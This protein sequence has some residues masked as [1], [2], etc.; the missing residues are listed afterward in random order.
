MSVANVLRKHNVAM[1]F[2]TTNGIQNRP[3]VKHQAGTLGLLESRIQV[4]K[5]SVMNKSDS[6]PN[7]NTL[8]GKEET[9]AEDTLQLARSNEDRAMSGDDR[10][11]SDCG[12][13]QKDLLEEQRMRKKKA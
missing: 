10:A 8:P 4:I 13:G 5:G 9:T 6:N 12:S 11:Q 3:G 1:P 2:I 7:L